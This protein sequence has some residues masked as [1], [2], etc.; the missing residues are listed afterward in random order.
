[1]SPC[2]SLPP[3]KKV[4]GRLLLCRK[5][6]LSRCRQFDLHTGLAMK[7]ILIVDDH[8]VVRDGVKRIL[9]KQP[10]AAAFGEASTATEALA[11]VREQAWDV[12]VLD[13]SLGGRDGLEVLRELKQIRPRLPVLILSMHSEELF[14]R[15]KTFV[16]ASWK[17]R[18]T[19]VA[20]SRFSSALPGGQSQWTVMPIRA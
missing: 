7:R 6:I 9:D 5:G 19:A 18:K 13:L 16:R 12:V 1:M 3:A 15:R 8:E 2:E 4:A 11:L 17:M 10:G 20:C 14:A